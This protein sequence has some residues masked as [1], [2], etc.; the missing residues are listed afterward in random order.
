MT[1]FFIALIFSS[2]SL[3]LSVTPA[4]A[5]GDYG[6]RTIASIAM[7]NVKPAT[8]ARITAL[9]RHSRE[10]AT[11]DCPIR[12]LEDAAVW[13]DCVRSYRPR[14]DYTA[15]WHYQNID[16]CKPFDIKS[17]CANGNCVSA[18]IDRT[19]KMLADRNLPSWYRVEALAELAHFVG[20]MHMPLHI[21]DR[22]DRGGNDVSAAWGIFAPE[23]LNLHSLWDWALAERALTTPPNVVRLYSAE[24]RTSLS[25]GTTANWAEEGWAVSRDAAYA[26]AL[27]GD[28]CGPKPTGRVTITEEDAQRLI[29]VAR[30]QVERAG[31]RLARMLDAALS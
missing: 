19:A 25:S 29:P 7:E 26:T 1:R 30:L 20:D 21:G 18:Q 9:L 28:P 11:P 27:D 4:S 8:R 10:L 13:S 6:H 17:A 12:N 16:V 3:T 24:E 22:A 15:P 31:L 2:L 5:W 14:F 23:R